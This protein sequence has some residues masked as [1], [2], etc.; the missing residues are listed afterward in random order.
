NP[1]MPILLVNRSYYPFVMNISAQR[2]ANALDSLGVPYTSLDRPIG[3]PA[4]PPPT[5]ADLS[6]YSLVVWVAHDYGALNAADE[7]ALAGYLD[8]GG[9][10]FLIAQQYLGD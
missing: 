10:L 4:A 2:A 7:E 3:S 1:S 5:A 9:R 6:P 8:G